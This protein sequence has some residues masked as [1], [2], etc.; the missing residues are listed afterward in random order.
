MSLIS[1]WSP[2]FLTQLF[3]LLWAN[4]ESLLNDLAA[5][6]TSAGNFLSPVDRSDELRQVFSG[7][8]DVSQCIK[9]IWP[10]LAFVSCWADGPSL[11][12]A[13]N[14]RQ[15]LPGIEIQ[16]KGLLATEAFV[17]MPLVSCAA[18]ALAIRSHFFEFLPMRTAADISTTRPLFAHELVAGD[19]YHVIVTTGG[20]LYRYQLHDTVEVV[21]FKGEV[22]LLRFVG[23]TDDVS[24]VVGEKLAAAQV[25]AVLQTAFRE[26]QLR[27][28]F[29]QLRVDESF[30]PRYVLQISESELLEN[31][32]LQTRLRNAVEAGLHAN[33]GYKYARAVGQLQPLAIELLNQ[34]QA[35]EVTEQAVAERVASGQRLGDIKPAT[36]RHQ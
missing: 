34:R 7:T 3:R 35:E 26:L 10:Q 32:A 24:D 17:S 20:G 14:L 4:R 36:V 22:P 9:V 30:P 8:V 13:N 23:K 19:Y 31:S 28:T 12:H 25:E 18:P 6:S 5:N 1:V 33:S 2:T 27:P 15:Y 21:G 16:P 11:A 29:A